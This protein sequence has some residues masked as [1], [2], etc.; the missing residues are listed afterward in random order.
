MRG[1]LVERVRIAEET[2]ERSPAQLRLLIAQGVDLGAAVAA[3]LQVLNDNPLID[4]EFFPG[5]LLQAILRLPTEFWESHH[6]L[7]L[8]A[9]AVLDRLDRAIGDLGTLRA[10]FVSLGVRD[11]P[12]RGD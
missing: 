7:W 12:R 9:H 2:V 4:A 5:D 11:G 1:S 6:D 10:G 3:A 8:E